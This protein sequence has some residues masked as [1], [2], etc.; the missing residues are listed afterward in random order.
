V[1]IRG[2]REHSL[3]GAYTL[4]SGLPGNSIYPEPSRIAQPD[5]VWN[6]QR[7]D[8]LE[9]ALCLINVFWSRNLG[10][11]ITL[12]RT[13]R[14]ILLT[15]GTLASY[16]FPTAKTVELPMPKDFVF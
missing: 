15:I 3:D 6:Y 11:A 4:L 16:K 12:K 10:A 14:E 13:G 1:S 2:F 7:G 8:G 9:K 5:E